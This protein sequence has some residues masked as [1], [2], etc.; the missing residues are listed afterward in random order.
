MTEYRTLPELPQSDF[1]TLEEIGSG[2]WVALAKNKAAGSN[3]GIVSLG[4]SALIFD[5]MET[6]QAAQDL[7]NAAERLTRTPVKHVINSHWHGDHVFGNQA[8]PGDALII[9]TTPTRD[10]IASN[11]PPRLKDR[12]T[13]KQILEQQI[14]ELKKQR[15]HTSDSAA[16]PD[17]IA[18]KKDIRLHE[19]LLAAVSMLNLRLPDW[20]FEQ[21]IVIYGQRRTVELR[22]FGGGHTD[23]DAILLIPEATPD[24]GTIAF[25]GDLLFHQE[26]PWVGDGYPARWRV[27]L[28]QVTALEPSVVVPG[29][30]PVATTAAFDPLRDYLAAMQDIVETFE[31]LQPPEDEE[32][33][34]DF[35][36]Q[37]LADLTERIAIPA[38]LSALTKPERFH[39]SIHALAQRRAK[40]V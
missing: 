39:R 18:L 9:S 33:P 31:L 7:L 38:E 14:R 16:T 17:Q 35:A 15:D 32:V 1:F 13:Q 4:D 36:E 5:T 8:M 12:R 40:Q 29:H 23:S 28:D 10:L 2:V 34:A 27:V 30:G 21:H 24:G 3:A 25:V 37:Q 11:I 20:T 6:P 26:H 19:T 22:S